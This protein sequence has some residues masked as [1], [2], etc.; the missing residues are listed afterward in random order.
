MPPDA[1]HRH[2]DYVTAHIQAA[3]PGVIP[4]VPNRNGP[5]ISW[6]R[7]EA[8][9]AVPVAAEKASELSEN[10]YPTDLKPPDI[11]R[12][13]TG[14]T[15]IDYVT[16]LEGPAP[17]PHVVLNALIHGNE[18]CGAVAL[19]RL[20]RREPR[21]ARGRLTFVFANVAAFDR[22]EPE[23]PAL[24]RFVDEDMNRVWDPDLLGGSR[25][26]VELDRA[27]AL[28]P[29]YGTA[30]HILDLH[31]MQNS[32]AVL[33]LCGLSERSRDLA[34]AIGFP[35]WVVRDGG[36]ASGRRLI[37]HPAFSTPGAGRTALLLECGQHWN[38]ASAEVAVEACLRHLRHFGMLEPD[39]AELPSPGAG[40][41]GQRVVEV[42]ETVTAATD[43]FVYLA[44]ASGLVVVPAAGTLIARDGRQDILTPYDDCVL[45]MPARR[46]HRGQTAVRLG[47]L[48]D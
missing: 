2:V 8:R 44:D 22:F 9:R 32:G 20:M 43:R 1:V 36:H 10:T 12:H 24:S 28:W 35:R 48:V 4:D 14:N 25:R 34:L 13:R 6:R 19:D 16:S 15:G 40:P 23:A 26:S 31:S 41:E 18:L 29:V 46:P 30:D 38:T 3:P 37:D 5:G 11:R 7:R 45:I 21:P 42:T 33:A 27:R 39:F 17:G 47:R